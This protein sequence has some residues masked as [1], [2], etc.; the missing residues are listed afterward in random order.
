MV[1]AHENA[2]Q[3]LQLR[4]DGEQPLAVLASKLNAFCATAQDRDAATVVIALGIT[5]PESRSWPGSVR[6]GDV[7]RW[8]RAVRRLERLPCASIAVAHGIC[9]GPSL[10]VLLATDYRIAAPD[11]KLLLPVNDGQFWPGMALYRLA[12]QAGLGRGRQLAL[13]GSELAA[14]R[15]ASIGI[16]DELSADVETAAEAAQVLFARLP[17]AEIAIRRQLL[18]EA[19][20]SSYE[21]ALGAHLAACDRELRRLGVTAGEDGDRGE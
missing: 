21:D 8:E 20:A 5:S 12:H 13:W 17:G 15:A 18:M 9:G 11:L 10:D 14:E 6:I 7:N 19:A 4:V 2:R 16:V 1:T 3:G